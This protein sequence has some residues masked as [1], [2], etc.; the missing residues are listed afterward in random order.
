MARQSFA[1]TSARR[2]VSAMAD[3]VVVLNDFSGGSLV[4][5]TSASGKKRMTVTYRSEALVHDFDAKAAG[6]LVA[7]AIAETL[8]S[9][10]KQIASTVSAAT[11][12]ARKTAAKAFSQG[13]PWAVKRYSGGKLGTMPPSGSDKQFNDSGRFAAG[14]A[15]NARSDG[16]TINV[17]ANRLNGDVLGEAGVM[18][19]WSKLAELVPE[20][21]NPAMLMDDLRVRGAVKQSLANM[22]QKAR[23][24]AAASRQ[25]FTDAAVGLA[26]RLVGGALR[27]GT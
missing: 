22:I 3:T 12:R 10:V 8:R 18:R 19:V 1:A 15:A 23:M 7:D 16:W 4:E 14:I 17:P 27:F 21:G 2:N 5:R 25:A 13:E 26:G 9:K 20:F 24:D 6:K 11:L